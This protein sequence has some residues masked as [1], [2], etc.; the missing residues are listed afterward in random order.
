GNRGPAYVTDFGFRLWGID[1]GATP[2]RLASPLNPIHI[3]NPGEDIAVGPGGRYLVVCDGSG[4]AP[5]SVGDPQ[6]G[7]EVSSFPLGTDCNAVDVCPDG[8]VLV[9]SYQSGFVK[10]LT[11]DGAGALTDTGETFQVSG[12]SNVYCARSSAAGIVVT[13]NDGITSLAIPGL[14][15]VDQR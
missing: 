6:T 12:P 7:R 5:V 15:A 3:S 11:L 13:F 4:T 8:S 10:R 14:T 2:P 1:L 9:T